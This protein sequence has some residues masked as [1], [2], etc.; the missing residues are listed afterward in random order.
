MTKEQ[1]KAYRPTQELREML[2]ILS[3]EKF[4]LDCGH[5]VTFNEVLGNNVTIYN[6]SKLRI[7][8]SECG[9]CS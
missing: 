5:H 4:I 3:R 6:G 8:C 9:Y 7:I 2:G 1:K